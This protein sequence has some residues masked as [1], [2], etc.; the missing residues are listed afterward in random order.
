M[1]RICRFSSHQHL[2]ALS[3]PSNVDTHTHTHNTTQLLPLTVCLSFSLTDEGRL[4][5]SLKKLRK[6]QS[7]PDQPNSSLAARAMFDRRVSEP[8]L[9]EQTHGGKK[10]K[11]ILGFFKKRNT[12]YGPLQEETGEVFGKRSPNV[13]ERRKKKGTASTSS[14]EDGMAAEDSPELQKK[15]PPGRPGSSPKPQKQRPGSGA[16]PAGEGSGKVLRQRRPPP[17][18]PSTVR[19]THVA[20]DTEKPGQRSSGGE[21]SPDQDGEVR[22]SSPRSP[23]S[24]PPGGS[25]SPETPPTEVADQ[26][27]AHPPI[28]VS[29]TPSPDSVQKSESMEEL[30]KTLEEFDE[31]ISSQNDAET[32]EIEGRERDFATIPRSELPPGLDRDGKSKSKSP[33][34]TPEPIRKPVIVENGHSP[35]SSSS[36]SPKPTAPPRRK[37]NKMSQ[38]LKDRVGIFEG[39]ES[40]KPV[41][42]PVRPAPKATSSVPPPKPERDERKRTRTRLEVMAT[43]RHESSSAPVSRNASPD[44]TDSSEF[45]HTPESKCL[46]IVLHTQG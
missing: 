21:V 23:P 18:V 7:N 3:T 25:R 9:T 44:I 12:Q 33:S 39:S 5:P 30:L 8:N 13:S 24:F 1:S 11:K 46:S 35:E 42:K 15:L 20:V 36:S 40:D 22:A 27:S 16:V 26:D 41:I 14:W 31:V 37:K 28:T 19:S 4:S 17:P 29:V 43:S 6:L 38:K 32:P 45:T 34:R 10:D 2:H